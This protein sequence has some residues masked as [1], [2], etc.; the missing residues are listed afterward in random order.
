MCGFVGAFSYS[1]RI[2]EYRDALDTGLARI[3]HRGPDATSRFTIESV[4]LGQNRLSIIDLSDAANQP[5]KDA[6]EDAW[7]VFNGEIYNYQTLRSNAAGRFLTNGDTEVLLRGYLAE[8][9]QF[10]TKLRGIYA[11]AILDKRTRTRLVL[12]RDPSGVKPLYWFRNAHLLAFASEIKALLPLVGHELSVNEP[13][14]KT[15]LNL[16]YCPE[17]HTIYR[18]IHALTPGHV[19]VVSEDDIRD[20]PTVKYDF[21]GENTHS[22]AENVER[23]E[24]LIDQAVRR[25]LVADVDL[26]VALSGGID[27]SLIYASARRH[28]PQINGLTMR[29]ADTAYDE[30]DVARVYADHVSGRHQVLDIQADFNLDLLDRILIHFDQPYADSSAIPTYYLTRAAR[31]HT[32]ILLGGDGGDELYN[33]YKSQTWLP[34]VQRLRDLPAGDTLMAGVL[35]VSRLAGAEARRISHRAQALAENP[36]DD[37][38][39]DWY[40]WLPRNTVYQCRSPFRYDRDAGLVTYQQM[41]A[42]DRPARF[43]RRV[44]FEHFTRSLLS[45]YLRKTDMM[46]M[47]NGVEYRVPLLDEDLVSF[48]L[49]IPFSQK[50]SIRQGKK[51]LRH[52]HARTYPSATSRAP[53]RGFAIPLDKYWTVDDLMR[54]R[55]ILLRPAGLA[56]SYIREEYISYLLDAAL[57]LQ[58]AS[59]HVSRAGV[60]Q[61]L[62]ILYA[63]ELWHINSSSR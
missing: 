6:D 26:A 24:S 16:G 5:L 30:S 63:L 60:Y 33:G 25:N 56:K 28:A 53:K 32:K 10:L 46:S 15:Y 40:S 4:Y 62:L 55:E 19:L 38:V 43:E 50:S 41:F 49:T 9:P 14:L 21:T 29:F 3:R 58:S 7:I 44:A 20:L 48:A 35:G 17:P 2:D 37:M 51:I 61:R 39:F 57:G 12:G 42:E 1:S 47:M 54:M 45:D 23:T 18:Q 31:R 36:A 34:Y 59:S 52:I 11:F 22:F 27:S 13:V 8:G